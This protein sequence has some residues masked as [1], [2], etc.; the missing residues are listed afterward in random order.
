MATPTWSAARSGLLGDT[1]ALNASAQL[2]QLL[3]THGVQLIYQGKQVV[4]PNGSG[5]G[6]IVSNK[7]LAQ[8]D[9]AQPFTM[10]GTTIGRV[11]V[12][13]IPVGSGADMVVSLY[14]NNA[15]V[16]GTLLNQ[17][18]V[19]ANWMTQLA[20]ANAQGSVGSAIVFNASGNQLALAQ[21][22]AW[23]MGQQVSGTWPYPSVNAS[24][25]AA[26]PASCYFGN[27]IILVGGVDNAHNVVNSVFTA[28]YDTV[29]NL[30]PSVPT[31]STPT[32]TDGSGKVVVV[33]DATSGTPTVVLVGGGTTYL[34]TPNANVFTAQFNATNGTLSTW[35]VQTVLPTIIQNQ[36]MATYNGYVYVIAGSN[37]S[38]TLSSVYYAQVQNGQITSWTAGPS[39][40]Q[41]LMLPYCAVSNGFLYVTSGTN[42]TFTT[43]YTTTYVS[44]LNANGSLGPWMLGPSFSSGSANLDQTIYGGSLGI[45]TNATGQN[46][47]LV[48][49]D[50]GDLF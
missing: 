1:G 6:T 34:G 16:P 7:A 32:V 48:T 49:P 27:Y 44:K 5:A 15:G 8:F 46:A 20:Y 41:S 19:P 47:M 50:G 35:T 39:L 13:V 30:S 43:N 28:F 18:R 3:G 38:N 14:T 24:G 10:S 29:G 42:I 26:S 45:I 22:N 17:A 40:P 31:S 36:G 33:T 23:R 2:N 11:T 9:V 4:A 37:G 25:G 21:F 12:P